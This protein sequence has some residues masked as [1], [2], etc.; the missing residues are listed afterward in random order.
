MPIYALNK[1]GVFD[2]ELLERFEAGIVLAGQEVKAIRSGLLSLKGSYVT[3]TARGATLLNAHI[4]AYPK[5]GKLEGY[6]PTHSRKLL[7]RKQEINELLGKIQQKG[8]TLLPVKVYA[9]HDRIKLEFAVARGRKQFDKRELIKQRE[10]KKRKR[11][12]LGG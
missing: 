1:R 4:G 7:L 9:S 5:A 6:D 10:W 11:Q 2:Y 12:A 8:L 3:V